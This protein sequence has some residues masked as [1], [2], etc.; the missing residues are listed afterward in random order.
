MH[1]LPK[2]PAKIT[3]DGLPDEE[4]SGLRRTADFRFT[5]NDVVR[6]PETSARAEHRETKAGNVGHVP[7]GGEQEKQKVFERREIATSKLSIGSARWQGESGDGPQ[8]SGFHSAGGR[9]I[10]LSEAARERASRIFA[11]L[12]AQ[13]AVGSV[14]GGRENEQQGAPQCVGFHSAGGKTIAVSEA[15]RQRASRIFAELNAEQ[16]NADD[17]LINRNPVNRTPAHISRTEMARNFETCTTFS[18]REDTRVTTSVSEGTGYRPLKPPGGSSNDQGNAVE[19]AVE[20]ATE[21]EPQ[22]TESAAK[23]A[24]DESEPDEFDDSFDVRY[25]QIAMITQNLKTA[26]AADAAD[27][28]ESDDILPWTQMEQMCKDASN[29]TQSE[30]E[31]SF[32]TADAGHDASTADGLEEYVSAADE[33]LQEAI[34]SELV[35]DLVDEACDRSAVERA[36]QE[37][38]TDVDQQQEEMRADDAHDSALPRQ[39]ITDSA[40][41]TEF[42][43]SMV[44]LADEAVKA[45]SLEPRDLE[46]ITSPTPKYEAT[47]HSYSRTFDASGGNDG[48]FMTASGYVETV[49]DDSVQRAKDLLSDIHTDDHTGGEP[50]PFTPFTQSVERTDV[51]VGDLIGS[52]FHGDTGGDGCHGDRASHYS[53]PEL[54][55]ESIA[56]AKH[57]HEHEPR[58]AAEAA[59]CGDEGLGP[60]TSAQPDENGD[61]ISPS[62]VQALM[63]CGSF[64][65]EPTETDEDLRTGSVDTTPRVSEW[66]ENVVPVDLNDRGVASEGHGNET[67]EHNDAESLDTFQNA[68]GN[69]SV[70]QNLQDEGI[71]GRGAGET[72]SS[73]KCPAKPP[74]EVEMN[75]ISAADSNRDSDTKVGPPSDDGASLVNSAHSP[76]FGFR[77]AAGQSPAAE[78]EDTTV[79]QR[80][81]FPTEGQSELPCFEQE[82][83]KA[84]GTKE[85]PV[86]KGFYTASG[87]KQ[88]V[89]E[90]SLRKAKARIAADNR[91]SNTAGDV[92]SAHSEFIGFRTAGGRKERVSEES[93]NLARAKFAE[94][95]RLCGLSRGPDG[96][97]VSSTESE[98]RRS[99]PSPKQEAP[100]V[101]ARTLRSGSSFGFQTAGGGSVSVKPE[102]L[103][104]A[105]RLSA[106]AG[107]SD[108]AQSADRERTC[109][110]NELENPKPQVAQFGGFSTANGNA[111]QVSEE[112]VRRARQMF[113]TLHEPDNQKNVVPQ[114]A[115]FATASGNKV[116]VS[117]ASLQRAKK[118]FSTTEEESAKADD[119]KFPSGFATARGDKVRVS[120]E[121]LKLARKV[122]STQEEGSAVNPSPSAPFSADKMSCT[123]FQT[124]KGKTVEVSRSA[125]EKARERSRDF[126]L[127]QEAAVPVLAKHDEEDGKAFTQGHSQPRT[128]G[129]QDSGFNPAELLEVERSVQ[130]RSHL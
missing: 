118:I 83:N 72:A 79:S 9:P 108:E 44:R 90:E 86:I 24:L 104:R 84:A 23:N 34:A 117:E 18:G 88:N 64:W 106:D 65:E 15:A 31:G 99:V 101:E 80:G 102:S 28:S 96:P 97:R 2:S 60:Y 55:T 115:G 48:S 40:W 43:D 82:S 27:F 35:S 94:A 13:E 89:L 5:V 3:E 120:E 98:E 78:S 58:E 87:K 103:Q 123:G 8:H 49:Q 93:L 100:K 128:R 29:E 67:H 10:S 116:T 52:S 113:S 21:T 119:P 12:D 25:S 92:S 126:E 109:E 22:E 39:E 41:D 4:A 32:R 63:A 1:E 54:E 130:V 122:L 50:I 62:E 114:A 51:Q 66:E 129:S 57:E 95:S 71:V 56:N 69:V 6:I 121:S 127:R 14:N 16:D 70:E 107:G 19:A 7:A 42:T 33:T 105:K 17:R 46:E 36:Q 68:S 124:A 61:E 112:S 73:D 110:E 45:V 30:S 75:S 77:A 26:E 74:E 81:L 53:P 20:E 37:Q 38:S 47:D 85:T 76:V 11:E 91:A 111:V 59:V 125:L